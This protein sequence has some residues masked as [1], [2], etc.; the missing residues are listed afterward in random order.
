MRHF[1]WSDRI[2]KIS[3][4]VLAVA[5]LALTAASPADAKVA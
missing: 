4:A 1:H 2:M 5:A 3:F